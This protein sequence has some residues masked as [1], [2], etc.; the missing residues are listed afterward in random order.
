V[1]DTGDVVLE[2][3]DPPCRANTTRGSVSDP[4]AYGCDL[5][6]GHDGPHITK[7]PLGPGS[8]TYAWRHGRHMTRI[9]DI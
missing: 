8:G 2:D 1:V 9:E 3:A 5:S 4:T 7:D 6:A